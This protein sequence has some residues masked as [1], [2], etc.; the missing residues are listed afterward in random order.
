MKRAKIEI[1]PMIDTM[2]FLLVFFMLSSLA[3]SRLL[4]IN[5]NL[6][7]ASTSATE[8]KVNLT[9]TI[10]ANE[11]IF[12][13]NQRAALAA[14][15]GLLQQDA[16]AAGVASQTVVINADMNVPHGLVVAAMDQARIAG[17]VHF[18]IAT[19]AGS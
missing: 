11:E 19:N 5:I 8:S 4:G 17:A 10:P 14:I 15:P 9:I 12:V 2:F 13:N 7:K 18:A 6:P 3:E 16:G 1:I